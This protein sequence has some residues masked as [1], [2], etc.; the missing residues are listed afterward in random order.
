MFRSIVMR[1][2][3]GSATVVIIALRQDGELFV[4]TRDGRTGTFSSWLSI[5][6]PFDIATG[7]RLALRQISNTWQVVGPGPQIVADVFAVSESGVLYRLVGWGGARWERTQQLADIAISSSAAGTAIFGYHSSGLRWGNPA[8]PPIAPRMTFQ[9]NFQTT[10]GPALPAAVGSRFLWL[11]DADATNVDG[12][13][14]RSTKQ[15]D[16]SWG[17][18][19]VF[20]TGED[21]TSSG[22]NRHWF[23]ADGSAFRGNSGELFVVGEKFHLRNYVP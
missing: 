20:A 3:V 19:Q 5:G 13:I 21:G 2:G 14:L 22:Q 1:P 9:W 7:E 10:Y 11:L 6:S 4:S 17:P 18:L 8:V 15:S 23:I 16:G 12:R